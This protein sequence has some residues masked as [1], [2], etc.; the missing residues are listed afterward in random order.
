MAPG[1]TPADL[2]LI[3]NFR[4]RTIQVLGAI[5]AA[6]GLAMAAYALTRLAGCPLPHCPPL[7]FRQDDV[8][9]LHGRLMEAEELRGVGSQ[10]ARVSLEEVHWLLRELYQGQSAR[11]GIARPDG[12]QAEGP[13]GLWR[14]TGGLVLA[15]WDAA[16]E[17]GPDNLVLLTF[18]E[19]EAHER[20][21][22]VELRA[23]EPHY[24]AKV[25]AALRRAAKE[26]GIMPWEG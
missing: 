3:P 26:F 22:L 11:A 14:P 19:A 16:K 4:I 1:Q 12:A 7:R 6:F 18:A 17:A 2:Q 21:S 10:G 5:P 9:A 23:R 25:E 8:A 24:V 15:R 20:G 13:K